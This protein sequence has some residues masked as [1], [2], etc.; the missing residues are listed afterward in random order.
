MAVTTVKLIIINIEKDYTYLTTRQQDWV[1]PRAEEV[2]RDVLYQIQDSRLLV[3]VPKE[4]S[5]E[6]E[7]ARKQG[8]SI[9][10][11]AIRDGMRYTGSMVEE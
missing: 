7:L 2:W 1:P 11:R 3:R 4:L 10:D 5:K 6:P 8:V 9:W